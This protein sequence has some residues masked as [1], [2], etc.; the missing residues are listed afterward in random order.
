MTVMCDKPVW[1]AWVN[2]DTTEGRGYQVPIAICEEEATA[3]RKARK[4]DVQGTDGSVSRVETLAI[5]GER[6]VP[7]EVV[8]ILRPTREDKAAQ[9][10]LD[11]RREV[12]AKARAAGLSDDDLRV[13]SR[14]EGE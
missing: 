7:A 11:K 12:L 9:A 2:S 14:T 3:R 1:V 13:L 10:V 8:Q 6:Y 4:K 5:D